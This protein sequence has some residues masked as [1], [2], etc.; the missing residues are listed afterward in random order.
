[1]DAKDEASHPEL[2]ENCQA[3][4]VYG[5]DHTRVR[6]TGRTEFVGHDQIESEETA[7]SEHVGADARRDE[8]SGPE[9]YDY[10]SEP[11]DTH[12]HVHQHVVSP[13]DQKRNIELS[14]NP[15]PHV[16]LETNREVA[17]RFDLVSQEECQGWEKHCNPRERDHQPRLETP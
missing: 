4:N 8:P 16:C 17:S 1:R 5:G 7:K 11:K 14:N 3:T 15:S 10:C 2:G 13:E 12:Q 9:P 6:G